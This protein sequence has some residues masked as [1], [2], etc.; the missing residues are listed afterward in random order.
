MT[1]HF[2][3]RPF[4]YVLLIAAGQTVRAYAWRSTGI[5]QPLESRL[6]GSLAVIG[7]NTCRSSAYDFLFTCHCN[8]VTVPKNAANF[9]E[10]TFI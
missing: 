6:P 4:P 8:H 2:V 3:T 9:S 7:T 5:T 1:P 10:P